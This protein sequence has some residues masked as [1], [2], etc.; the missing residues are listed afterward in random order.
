MGHRRDP[1]PRSDGSKAKVRPIPD[2]T[3]GGRGSA[4]QGPF[5][6]ARGGPAGASQGGAPR[7][8]SRVEP[9]HLHEQRK[10]DRGRKG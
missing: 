1:V 6:N 7:G 2:P 10:K 4:V 5:A 8:G 3:Q 9:S